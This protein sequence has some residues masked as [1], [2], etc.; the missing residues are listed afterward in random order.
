MHEEADLLYSIGEVR[1]R[2]DEVLECTSEAPVLRGVSNWSA[3]CGG[4]L[5]P[6]VHRGG[7]RVALGH[8]STLEKIDDVLSL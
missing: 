3:L 2:Q 4:Q 8:A 6:G 1:P 5:G 7:S